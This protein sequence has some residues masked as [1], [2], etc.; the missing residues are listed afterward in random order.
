MLSV[1]LVTFGICKRKLES[2]LDFDISLG[3]FFLSICDATQ[4]VFKDVCS[5]RLTPVCS[6]SFNVLDGVLVSEVLQN[7]QQNDSS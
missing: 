1:A 2:D 5:S 7:L 4:Y 6:H 3:W